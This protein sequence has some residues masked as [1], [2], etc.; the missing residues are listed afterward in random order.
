VNQIDPLARELIKLRKASQHL[1]QFDMDGWLT[2]VAEEVRVT[3]RL[4]SLLLCQ[5]TA[6]T[7]DPAV[8]ELL[9]SIDRTDLLD[10]D[11]AGMD[12]LWGCISPEEYATRLAMVDVLVAPFRLPFELEQS[13]R[14]ARAC[15]AIGHDVAVQSLSRTI[16]EAAVNDIAVRAGRMPREAVEQDMFK[17]YPPKAR[18]RLVSGNQFEAIYRHYR[19]LCK[20][21]HGLTAQSAEGSLGSLTKTIGYVQYLY[22]TNKSAILNP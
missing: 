10:L 14:E 12:L 9:A 17:D 16:L 6:V 8:K 7:D 4:Q 11:R 3:K 15:Y 13:L 19:E 22:E 21:V 18:I 1:L 2:N 5:P 20:V